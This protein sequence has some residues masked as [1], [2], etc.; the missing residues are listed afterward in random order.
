MPFPITVF[1]LFLILKKTAQEA[2]TFH[3]DEST[4]IWYEPEA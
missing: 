2:Y 1:L 4:S 3:P